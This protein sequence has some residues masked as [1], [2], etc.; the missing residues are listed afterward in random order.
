MVTDNAH[1]RMAI[2]INISRKAGRKTRVKT[3]SGNNTNK[4]LNATLKK[5]NREASDIDPI[6][7]M[8]KDRDSRIVAFLSRRAWYVA[9]ATAP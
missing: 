8:Q 3:I 6:L 2:M 7:G 4:L 5:I 9:Y 1:I